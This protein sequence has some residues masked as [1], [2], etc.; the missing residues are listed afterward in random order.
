[1]VAEMK[2]PH[3][4]GPAEGQRARAGLFEG[5]QEGFC[6]GRAPVPGFP[7]GPAHYSQEGLGCALQPATL[8]LW[9]GDPGQGCSKK[10]TAGTRRFPSAES[11]SK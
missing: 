10:R 7:Q 9:V 3:Q 11:A 1:M 5:L 6:S 8:Q 2:N 4:P